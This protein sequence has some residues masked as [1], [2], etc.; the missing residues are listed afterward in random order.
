MSPTT[1]SAQLEVFLSQFGKLDKTPISDEHVLRLEWFFKDL[2]VN[3]VTPKNREEFLRILKE[4]DLIKL[5][6]FLANNVPDF[7]E[8]ITEFFNQD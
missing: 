7:S 6:S 4:N 1:P 2:A 8:K 5:A 3:A